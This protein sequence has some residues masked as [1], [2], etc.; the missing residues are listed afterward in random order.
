MALHTDTKIGCIHWEKLA[1]P[2]H[3]GAEPSRAG[4]IPYSCIKKVHVLTNGSYK[5]ST[6][7]HEHHPKT[8]DHCALK[9]RKSADLARLMA[10]DAPVRPPVG[11]DEEAHRRR[12]C[13]VD[14]STAATDGVGR[15]HYAEKGKRKWHTVVNSFEFGE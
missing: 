7:P 8:L 6:R 5:D 1:A 11:D 14:W 2:L 10:P 4:E 12:G 15:H 13:S 3:G 9:L